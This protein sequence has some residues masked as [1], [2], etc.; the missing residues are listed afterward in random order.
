MRVLTATT[1]G[2]ETAHVLLPG[3][4]SKALGLLHPATNLVV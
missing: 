4:M 1:A 3:T 2:Y